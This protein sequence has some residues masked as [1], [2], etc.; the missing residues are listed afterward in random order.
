MVPVI[1]ISDANYERLK[2]W[3]IPLEDSVDDALGKALAAANEHGNCRNEEQTTAPELPLNA[4]AVQPN[5]PHEARDRQPTKNGRLHRGE[6]IPMKDFMAPILEVI[7][8]LGGS[9][10]SNQVLEL[11][12]LRMRPHLEDID[13]QPIPSGGEI[14]WHK[15]ANWA[16]YALIQRGLLQANSK[17]GVW[18]LTQQGIDEIEHK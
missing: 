15:K 5:P 12:E 2:E 6:G 8:Q 1:R 14:R 11:V 3:A 9:A 18:E 4:S 10:R 7:Y 16:R 13:Y 17:W